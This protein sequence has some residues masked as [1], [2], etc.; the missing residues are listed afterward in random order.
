VEIG[1]Q[2]L[3]GIQLSGS[4]NPHLLWLGWNNQ[5]EDQFPTVDRLQENSANLDLAQLPQDDLW[6]HSSSFW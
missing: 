1:I 3:L 6:R 4:E 5:T 2:P